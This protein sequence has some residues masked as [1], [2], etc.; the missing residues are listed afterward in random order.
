MVV[1][2]KMLEELVI[3]DIHPLMVAVEDHTPT[4]QQVLLF[5]LA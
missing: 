2:K 4:T 5:L 3:M 1:M